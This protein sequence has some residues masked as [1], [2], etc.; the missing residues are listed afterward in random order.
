MEQAELSAIRDIAGLVFYIFVKL[1][2]LKNTYMLY[3]RI[4]Y[5]GIEKANYF[6]YK[7]MGESESSKI[8]LIK[9]N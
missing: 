8:K 5:L 6:Y 9:K 7:N 4:L 2:Y 1:I 3:Y